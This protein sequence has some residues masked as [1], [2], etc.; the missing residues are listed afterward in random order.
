[1]YIHEYQA[2]ELLA[3][4][5][6]IVPRGTVAHTPEEAENAAGAAE[7]GP[8]MVK[9]QIHAGGR[10]KGGGAKLCQTPAEVRTA[11]ETMLGMTLVTPQ[12]GPTG[13]LVHKVL[14]EEGVDIRRELYLAVV[15]NRSDRTLCLVASPHGGMDIEETAVTHPERI[16]S[17][18]LDADLHLWPFQARQA[19]FHLGLEPTHLRAGVDLMD[20][21]IR[22]CLEKDAML[23]EINPLA[24]TGNGALVPLDAKITFDD[25]AL[26]RRPEIAALKDPDEMDPLERKAAELGVNY[27]RLNGWVGTMVNGAGLAMATIDAVKQAG[28][29]PANFLD[30]GGGA[31]V[32]SVRRG[33][34]IMLAD[35]A[36]RGVLINIFGGILRCDIVAKGVIEAARSLNLRLPVVVRMEGTNVEEARALL[37]SSGLGFFSA[38]DMAEAVRLI[39]EKTAGGRA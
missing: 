30:A 29:E 11:A 28:A 13:K 20:K 9:A 2:K 36:V 5:G 7:R 21:L 27:V 14:V 19:L 12:T 37:E 31:D 35:P 39:V 6:V 8:W 23:L 24:L 1:M 38:S 32:E 33:F 22:F 17:L 25:S 10:G 18:N 3:E 34:E 26:P 4:F 15:L 16:L